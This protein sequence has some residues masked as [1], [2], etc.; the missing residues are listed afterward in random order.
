MTLP[1]K[2]EFLAWKDSPMTKWVLSR[3]QQQTQEQAQDLQDR[4]L[5][6]VVQEPAQWQSQQ[7]QAAYLKGRF[8]HAI[9]LVNA[10][11][12]DFLTADET[13]ALN[14]QEATI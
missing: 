14:K 8:D 9:S 11:Y 6:S 3:L 10:D 2:E 1:D 4:L 5:N 12:E 13:E 7:P